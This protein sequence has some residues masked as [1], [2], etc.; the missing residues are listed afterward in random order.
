MDIHPGISYRQPELEPSICTRNVGPTEANIHPGNLHV[1]PT[2][3]TPDGSRT[4]TVIEPVI[5]WP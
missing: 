1:A 5:C 4:E 3:T 2:I